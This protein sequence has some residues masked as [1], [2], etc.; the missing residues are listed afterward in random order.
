MASSIEMPFGVLCV[1]MLS[2]KFSYVQVCCP[3]KHSKINPFGKLLDYNKI[4]RTYN[5]GISRSN[6]FLYLF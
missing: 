2:H 6:S 5:V 3:L 1:L 4:D